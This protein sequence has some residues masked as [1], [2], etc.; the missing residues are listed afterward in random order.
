MYGDQYMVDGRREHLVTYPIPR[1]VYDE[2]YQILNE[3]KTLFVPIVV[4][5]NKPRIYLEPSIKGSDAICRVFWRPADI[6]KHVDSLIRK[7]TS[8]G[9]IVGWE[10]TSESVVKSLIAAGTK[11]PEL[12]IKAITS[13]FLDGGIRDLE[14]FWQ[15]LLFDML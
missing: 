6:K 10:A 5:E 9:K 15:N 7:T 14:V 12:K 13:V 4:N 11:L 2:F 1:E 8:D 3:G